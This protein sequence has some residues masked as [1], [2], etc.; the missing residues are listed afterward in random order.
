MA[1][2]D[3]LYTEKTILVSAD[4]AVLYDM[5]TD[6]TRM[7]EWSPVCKSCWWDDGQAPKVGSWFTGH[8][9][10]E[11]RQ[12]DTR[13]EV[14]TATRPREFAWIVGGKEEGYVRWGYR[15]VPSGDKTSVTES[16]RVLRQTERIAAMD[17]A[18]V[19]AYVERTE[20]GIEETLENL[21]R[22]AEAAPVLPS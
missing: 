17:N 15:F 12:W 3:A 16:W 20:R 10:L 6:V 7:G 1:S 21:K 9:V 8:N 4:P 19:P 5:I 22:V 13:C 14:V 18:D 11:E 2:I